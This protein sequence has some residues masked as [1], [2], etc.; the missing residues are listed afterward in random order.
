MGTSRLS[1][2]GTAFGFGDGVSAT[3]ERVETRVITT[4]ASPR[5]DTI[6]LLRGY[7]ILGVVLLHLS[8]LLS[9]SGQAV[10]GSLPK[11]LKYIVFSEGGN[12]V[13]AFF[14]V[15]GFLITFV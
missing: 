10:G 12:G 14:A 8:N 6:D 5:Y 3:R 13:S 15:S 2:G 9:A 4:A 11:W 7:A 1:L